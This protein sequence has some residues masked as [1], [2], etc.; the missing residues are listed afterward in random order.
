MIAQAGGRP[1]KI[2]QESPSQVAQLERGRLR[3]YDSAML[4]SH[5][6]AELL[7]AA[8]GLDDALYQACERFL[9]LEKSGD[10]AGSEL[11][12]PCRVF[13]LADDIGLDGRSRSLGR[14]ALALL[15]QIFCGECIL[16][17]P[18]AGSA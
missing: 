16:G 9:A 4:D 7:I 18:K 11:W 5:E 10:H 1:A 15:W 13:D 3:P 17:I 2:F 8:H 12:S 6:M 14:H